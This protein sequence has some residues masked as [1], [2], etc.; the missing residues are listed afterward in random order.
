MET[1]RRHVSV[2]SSPLR[3]LHI[4]EIRV[5]PTSSQESTPMSRWWLTGIGRGRPRG[6]STATS[7]SQSASNEASP[8]VTGHSF[9]A[10][11]TGA[12]THRGCC[13][14]S[15]RWQTANATARSSTAISTAAAASI[16]ANP[17]VVVALSVLIPRE[18][19]ERLK[20]RR[21]PECRQP[22]TEGERR[23]NRE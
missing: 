12:A 11:A 10:T 19:E 14:A 5:V 6:L 9:A 21:H 17:G 3:P 16:T 4:C 1:D 20:A 18:A 23:K 15:S 22:T 2:Y 13:R 7:L 8:I